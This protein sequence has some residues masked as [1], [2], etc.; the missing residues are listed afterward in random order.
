M[1][2]PG[3]MQELVGPRDKVLPVGRI[4]VSAVMLS[5]GELPVQESCI[6]RRHPGDAIVRRDTKIFHAKQAKYRLRGDCGH[7][8]SLLIEPLRVTFFRHAVTHE[9]RTR[10]AECEQFMGIYRE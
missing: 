2:R 7:E 3:M 4:R 5:P 1:R 10:C 9:S 6:Y 8:T